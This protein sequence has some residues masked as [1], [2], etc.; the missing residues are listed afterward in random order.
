MSLTEGVTFSTL[1][2]ED[3]IGKLVIYSFKVEIEQV[4]GAKRF[5]LGGEPCFSRGGPIVSKHG[6]IPT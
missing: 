2:R 1:F 5:L 3:R 6:T 4:K